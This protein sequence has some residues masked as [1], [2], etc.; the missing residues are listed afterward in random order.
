V[1]DDF[2]WGV[3]IVPVGVPVVGV[4]V[5]VMS[6]AWGCDGMDCVDCV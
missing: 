4:G 6:R 3:E 2:A 1:G 5:V